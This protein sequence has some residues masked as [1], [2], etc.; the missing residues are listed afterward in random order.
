M[1]QRSQCIKASDYTSRFGYPALRALTRVVR[2]VSKCAE[3]E[4]RG[5]LVAKCFRSQSAHKALCQGQEHRGTFWNLW[6]SPASS[7]RSKGYSQKSITYNMTP[8]LHTSASLPSYVLLFA[9]TSGAAHKCLLVGPH[10]ATPIITSM[11]VPSLGC[12]GGH[13]EGGMTTFQRQRQRGA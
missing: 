3:R 11:G 2:H 13:M 8:L 1:M 9:M 6:G 12:N 4:G 7:A 10:V 5:A